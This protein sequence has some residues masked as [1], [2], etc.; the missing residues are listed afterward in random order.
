MLRS[1]TKLLMKD[2]EG[3]MREPETFLPDPL[4]VRGGWLRLWYTS[5][6]LG[7]GINWKPASEPLLFSERYGCKRHITLFGWRF[8]YLEPE[9]RTP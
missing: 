2:R 6:S 8:G 9:R 5:R 7:P 1:M 4:V 3:T